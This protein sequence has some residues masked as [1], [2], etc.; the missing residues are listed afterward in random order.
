LAKALRSRWE[1][2]RAELRRCQDDFSEQTVHKLRVATRRLIAQ[3]DI[4]GCVTPGTTAE[5]AR[6][7]LKGRL[8]A[9]GELRD[10]HVQ[11]LF[12]ERRMERFPELILVRDFLQRRERG[13]ERAAAAKVKGFKTRKLE[14]W[15]LGLEVHLTRK[16]AQARRPDRLATIVARATTKAFLA[17]ASRREA[18]DPA[19][20]STIHRTRVAFKKFRYMLES[21]SPDFTGL[22]KRELRR[23]ANYQRRMGILQD[24]EV[25]QQCVTA[26]VHEREGINALL[27]PFTRYL[28]ASR[29]RALR[30]FLKSAD[31]LFGFWPPGTLGTN[32][33]IAAARRQIRVDRKLGGSTLFT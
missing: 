11:R 25:M 12:I 27:A 4:A 26:F 6:W 16:P 1:S 7:C 9:L 31:E 15:T 10:T 3:F 22:S 29:A 23:L 8:K 18:M 33:D 17:V 2:Y 20:P 19:N 30:S 24:L 32:V 13:L 21:L 14:E 28:R 5:K